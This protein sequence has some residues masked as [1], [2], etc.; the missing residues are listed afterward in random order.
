MPFDILVRN[1][2]VID[3]TGNPWFRADVAVRAGRI[4]AVGPHLP[5]EAAEIVDASA[6]VACPGFIDAHTHSD[7]VFFIEPTAQSKVRQGVTTEV[8][9][10]CGMSGAPY[11][12]GAKEKLLPA[13]RGFVPFWESVPEYLQALATQ[14]KP[15]NV[16]PLVGHG[17]LRAAVVGHQDRPATAEEQVREAQAQ[18]EDREHREAQAQVGLARHVGEQPRHERTDAGRRDDAHR[19]PHPEGTEEPVGRAADPPGQEPGHAE[20]P[21]PEHG[22]RER[23]HHDRLEDQDPGVLEGRPEG[24]PGGRGHHTKGRVHQD[25]PQHEGRGEAEGR[26]PRLAGLA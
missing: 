11:F 7:Y 9:G 21:E 23:G 22:G 25:H 17:T 6:S 24:A 26:T 20:L 15:V 12:G 5:G 18:R 2:R 13:S 3:G 19:E 8:I 10:N 1:A 16:A 4:E 14:P